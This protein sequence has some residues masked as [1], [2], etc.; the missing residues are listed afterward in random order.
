MYKMLLI[1]IDGTLIK[2]D[3]T[4]PKENIRAIKEASKKGLKVIISTGRMF[5]S[6]K[7]FTDEL[8]IKD[9]IITSNGAYVSSNNLDTIY[10]EENL[11]PEDVLFVSEVL[12]PYGSFW[13]FFN[14]NTM[15]VEEIKEYVS[16]FERMFKS[17]PF[18]ERIN[19]KYLDENFTVDNLISQYGNQ[20]QKGIVFL[21]KGEVEEV[22]KKLIVNNNISVVSSTSSN[23]EVTH[24]NADKGKAALSLAKSFNI[25]P[26]EIM[27][28][29]DSGNDLSM[30]EAVGF[31]VAMGNA[32]DEL[33]NAAKF[34]TD[35]NENF[36]VAKAIDK[37]ILGKN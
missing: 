36:G 26:E 10:Y 9:P 23:I 27:C 15:F 3:L 14:H 31:P 28:L 32:V 22:T 18:T 8:G 24:K 11:D 20:I 13:N 16:R 30:F 25:K 4:I 17:V 19:V 33:K 2:E 34:I 35:T 1:D 7:Q 21:E 37:F 6:A 29:G 5:L 12:K